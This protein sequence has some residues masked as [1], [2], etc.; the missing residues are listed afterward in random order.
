MVHKEMSSEHGVNVDCPQQFCGLAMVGK[1]M[2]SLD[3][4]IAFA[5][6]R[7]CLRKPTASSRSVT[8]T[9]YTGR[10]RTIEPA[11]VPCAHA[12]RARNIPSP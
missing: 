11:G 8:G 4:R 9:A 7:V 3:Q 12:R 6:L 5:E 1:L 10:K 2:A